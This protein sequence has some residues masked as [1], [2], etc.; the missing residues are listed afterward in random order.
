MGRLA[1]YRK[2]ITLTEGTVPPGLDRVE[3][4]ISIAGRI[5]K[6]RFSNAPNQSTTF[7]W[8]GVD[9]YGRT[10]QGPQ[11]AKIRIGYRF[12]TQYVSAS[13]GPQAFAS[14]PANSLT[15]A[16]RIDLSVTFWQEFETSVG[17]FNATGVGI[18][19]WTLSPHH[20]YVKS[21]SSPLPSPRSP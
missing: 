8:D 7:A 21:V 2:T 3:L 17:A 6:Q 4:E 19:G 13:A 1:Q 11:A 10:L 5:F 20:V 18:G 9:A 12:P 16:D 14:Y 15:I